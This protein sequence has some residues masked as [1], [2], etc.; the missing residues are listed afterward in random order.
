M[1]V[2]SSPSVRTDSFN[3]TIYIYSLTICLFYKYLRGIAKNS[4]YA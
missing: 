3:F 4:K 1:I 2:A